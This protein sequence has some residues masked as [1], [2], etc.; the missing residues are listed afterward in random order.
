VAGVIVTGRR[1]VDAF[2]R[3]ERDFAAGLGQSIAVAVRQT[4]LYQDLQ[5]AY[6]DLRET[7]LAV[8]QQER[9][10]ALGEMAS[11]IAHDINNAIAPIPLFTQ[12]LENE[13]DLSEQGRTYLST[14]STA[15][16]NVE[17]TVRRMRQFYRQQ[18]EEKLLPLD[19]NQA[20]VEA[21]EL[22]RP[23]WRDVP[24]EDGVTIDLRTDFQD[25]LPR[26]MGNDGEIRQAVINLILNA[27][28]A[29]PEGGTLTV[30]TRRTVVSPVHVILEVIDTGIGMDAETR[31]RCFEPFFTTKGVRGTGMGLATVYGT[32]QRHGGDARVHSALGEGTTMQLIFPVQELGED[33]VTERPAAHARALRILCVDDEPLLR[34]ALRETLEG[35]GHTVELADGGETGL[36]VFRAAYRRGQPFDVVVTDLGMAYVDGRQVARTV[37]AEAPGTPVILLTGWGYRMNVEHDV[38][39]GVD[40]VLSKPPRMKALNRA[41]ARV[42]SEADPPLGSGSIEHAMGSQA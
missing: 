39:A 21:I 6:D 25:D 35:E 20:A 24:Q 30:R 33:S 19:V 36:D 40:L 32:M 23:G 22:T 38:P 10:Q 3:P 9:L 29:M 7:Q 11:G 28:D 18:E 2:S 34:Q 15:I 26:V 5:A 12:L 37:K 13:P 42:T 27:V 8:M 31:E 41:L 4:Q 1:G 17:V 14:I 16:S